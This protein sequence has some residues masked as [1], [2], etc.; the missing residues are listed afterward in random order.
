MILNGNVRFN[1]MSNASLWLSQ[2]RRCNVYVAQPD[3]ADTGGFAA[4][5]DENQRHDQYAVHFYLQRALAAHPWRVE[6]RSA[7]DVIFFNASFTFH[8]GD[9]EAVRESLRKGLQ[10]EV[11]R[12]APDAGTACVPS[13]WPLL[14]ATSFSHHQKLPGMGNGVHLVKELRSSPYDLIAPFVVARPA[15]LVQSHSVAPCQGPR[16]APPSVPWAARKLV[17]FAGHVPMLYI[18]TTRF[19]IWSQLHTDSTRASVH[20]ST[21]CRSRAYVG[22]DKSDAE[23]L[24]G[25]PRFFQ[26]ECLAACSLCNGGSCNPKESK[27]CLGRTV[28]NSSIPSGSLG[29]FRRQCLPYMATNFSAI[30]R[31]AS[32]HFENKGLSQA[33]YY[34]KAMAH[35]FCIVAPGDYVSTRKVTESI[36]IAAA[37]G[38]LPLFVGEDN[39]QRPYADHVNYCSVGFIISTW[40][41]E[42]AL[43]G[44]L[45]RLSAVT[46]AERR[47][48][49]VHAEGLLAAFVYREQSS[50]AKPSAAEIIIAEWCNLAHRQRAAKQEREKEAM[51]GRLSLWQQR[52]LA[53]CTDGGKSRTTQAS[54]AAAATPSRCFPPHLASNFA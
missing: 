32:A 31:A 6:S 1:R 15:W 12:L 14:F 53:A 50:F 54:A 48:R 27:W 46:E 26:A 38:C 7:A 43:A 51:A 33:D 42:H 45:H 8:L 52:H 5:I 3:I 41:A 28:I 37:G 44:V 39:S 9:R 11:S 23:L 29:H 2:Q 30:Y 35:R 40:Q 21:L 47:L 17:F 13:T 10:R 16:C 20:V 4:P 24:S 36:A 49:Q 18:S 25:D 19:N 34:A 22:C